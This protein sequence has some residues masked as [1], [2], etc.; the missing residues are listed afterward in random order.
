MS[1]L[2]FNFTVTFAD[3]TVKYGF[4]ELD[5]ITTKTSTG[6]TYKLVY[7]DPC[8]C[9]VKK[10]KDITFNIINLAWADVYSTVLP[11]IGKESQTSGLVLYDTKF[12]ISNPISYFKEIDTIEIDTVTE[13]AN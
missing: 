5:I 9:K 13:I 8:D 12:Y 1:G 10:N 3:T 11:L 2:Q 4:L 7:V 6:D